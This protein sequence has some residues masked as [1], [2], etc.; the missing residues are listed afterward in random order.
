MVFGIVIGVTELI[1]GL[2]KRSRAGPTR[3][4]KG[5]LWVFWA[6]IP[7][8]IWFAVYLATNVRVGRFPL[9]PAI[10]SAAVALFAAGL[11]LRWYSIAY[12]GRLFTVDVAIAPDHRLV[13]RGPYRYI[14][15]PSYTG[16]LLAV[17]GL[18]L[19]MGDGL[20][21]LA[22]LLPVIVCYVYRIRIEETALRAGLGAAYVDYC[23]RT[24]RLIPG[25]F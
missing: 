3:A 1:I 16:A 7:A 17:L 21:L 14:R 25:V 4:D 12:L 13:D 24:R 10:E 20:S 18:A 6:L 23:A 15:H 5:S 22:I 9:S 19:S 11:A 8:G 2:V